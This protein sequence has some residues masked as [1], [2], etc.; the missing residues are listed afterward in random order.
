MRAADAPPA[1]NQSLDAQRLKRT[2]R[3]IVGLCLMRAALCFSLAPAARI[4]DID[5]EV[6]VMH[7]SILKLMPGQQILCTELI[8]PR[9]AAALPNAQRRSAR[10]D[11]NA[12]KSRHLGAQ[13]AV[14]L[15]DLAISARSASPSLST[16]T[17]FTCVALT[18]LSPGT[19]VAY[20]RTME[21]LGGNL[22][23]LAA[24]RQ[25]ARYS[26]PSGKVV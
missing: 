7:N 17:P 3:D 20:R 19:P 12:R 4:V 16:H 15:L 8:A 25:R 1:E 26:R 18:S 5:R 21:T 23:S 6:G 2:H 14:D 9:N 11:V 10:S 13:E 24:W 22:P